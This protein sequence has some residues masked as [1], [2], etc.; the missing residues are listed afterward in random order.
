[1]STRNILGAIFITFG[2][3]VLFMLAFTEK[4][5]PV[6][7]IS[8]PTGIDSMDLYT[9]F[10]TYRYLLI[11]DVTFNR[12]SL[13]AYSNNKTP[14]CIIMR[15]TNGTGAP[16]RTLSKN[17]YNTTIV[18]RT[19]DSVSVRLYLPNDVGIYRVICMGESLRAGDLEEMTEGIVQID[20]SELRYQ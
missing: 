8:E 9:A 20:T 14:S 19:N 12:G 16:K 10:S 1:M 13:V 18:E 2:I 11:S 4:I 7:V 6:K 5:E 3:I 17:F 15:D